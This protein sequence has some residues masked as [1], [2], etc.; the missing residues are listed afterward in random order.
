MV[1]DACGLV[2]LTGRPKV[3]GD[4]K[5]PEMF[6]VGGKHANLS[7]HK[8]ATKDMA[9]HSLSPGEEEEEEAVF[10]RGVNK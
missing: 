4:Q 6:G 5:N 2:V 3:A 7:T 8:H 9:N 1:F 10:F